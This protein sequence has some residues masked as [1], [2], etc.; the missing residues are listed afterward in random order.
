MK[1]KKYLL[2]GLVSLIATSCSEDAMDSI[3]KDTHNPPAGEV[4]TKFQITDGIVA[5]A[6][7]TSSGLYAWYASSFT[8]Q[9]FGTGN[10]QAMRIEL[11]NRIETM[12][13]T[14]YNNE[15][16]GTYSNLRNLKEIMDKCNIKGGTENGKIDIL[17]MAQ[18]L[19]ALNFGILTDLHGDIPC[20]EA[21]KGQANLQPNLDKQSD[22]YKNTIFKNLDDAIA[23][24]EIAMSK[25]NDKGEYTI[26]N[27]GSQDF[28]FKNN[29]KEWLATAHAL[30]AR[31]LLH[32]LKINP[33]VLVDVVKEAEAAIALDFAGAS[34]DIFNEGA[35]NNPWTAY[36]WSRMYTGSSKTVIDLMNARNDGRVS[37]YNFNMMGND[38]YGTPG[39][40]TQARLT[41]ALNAPAWL[42]VGAADINLISSQ[43]LYFILAEAKARLGQNAESA[44]KQGVEASFEDYAEFGKV[45][46]PAA[47]ITSIM[48][49]FTA[50]PLAE[51]MVQKYLSQCRDEQ[52]EAYNDIRRC[53]AVDGASFVKM[54]N[55]KNADNNWPQRFPYGNSSVLANPH[56]TQAYGD[57][58][59]IF[60]EKV[61]WAGGER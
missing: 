60:T 41:E 28:L 25:V 55:P 9:E 6:F 1:I 52:I 59:Y 26:Q 48:A 11:R 37:V 2:I 45:G 56:M 18:M 16:N 27:A 58:T 46:E 17:G 43:E 21:L 31:Y 54:T 51:I 10:N 49:K 29:H 39:D 50:Q 19:T 57:G 35:T 23:N 34:L 42:N 53:I 7:S 44:F 47:Y 3:N 40:E 5:T 24:F 14:A 38:V 4:P 32:T 61:W 15:W 8:E 30:K 12:S 13:S 33:E 22:I 36:Y 20:S